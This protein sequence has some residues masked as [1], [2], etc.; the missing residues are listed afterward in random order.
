MEEEALDDLLRSIDASTGATGASGVGGGVQGGS[1]GPLSSKSNVSNAQ[2]ERELDELLGLVSPSNQQHQPQRLALP[3]SNPLGRAPPALLY[4]QQINNNQPHLHHQQQQLFVNQQYNSNNPFQHQQQPQ[5]QQLRQDPVLVSSSPM[6]LKKPSPQPA[7]ESADSSNDVIDLTDEF[8]DELDEFIIPERKPIPPPQKR[9]T[10]SSFP[11]PIAQRPFGQKTPG[12]EHQQRFRQGLIN[13]S[14]AS[15]SSSSTSSSPII[16]LENPADILKLKLEARERDAKRQEEQKRLL[17]EPCCFGTLHVNIVDFSPLHYARCFQNLPMMQVRL[18]P[19]TPNSPGATTGQAGTPADFKI[20]VIGLDVGKNQHHLGYI[21]KKV[22]IVLMR[23]LQQLKMD[24]WIPNTLPTGT[25][26]PIMLTLIGPRGIAATLGSWLLQ[27]NLF[28]SDV[29]TPNI[30]ASIPRLNPQAGFKSGGGGYMGTT[31][32]TTVHLNSGN[33]SAAEEA[34]TQIE[35]VY[36]SLTAAENLP[37]ME[38]DD[39][40]LTPMYAHQ[41]QALHFMSEKEKDVDFAKYDPKTSIWKFDGRGMY[42]NMITNEKT[43]KKPNNTKGGIL[44]DDMGLGKTIEVISLIMTSR[45][46]VRL[47]AVPAYKP[48]A[49]I[50]MRRPNSA[51]TSQPNSAPTTPIP[52]TVPGFPSPLTQQYQPSQ[53]QYPYQPQHPQN[54]QFFQHHDQ[55]LHQLLTQPPQQQ[56]QQQHQ[57]PQYEIFNVHDDDDEPEDDVMPVRDD[58]DSSLY[59]SQGTLIVCPLSTVQNWEEQFGAHVKPNTVKI[60]VYH[61]PNR[62][63]DPKELAKYDIVI[64]TYN[65]LSIEYG[66]DIKSGSMSVKNS[67][68]AYNDV[69]HT[70]ITV[71][72]TL[73]LVKWYRIVLD[74][75]H[76]IKDPNTAQ[77]KAACS[78]TG[79][80]RWALTGTPIQ[81]KLDDLFSLIKFLRIQPFCNKSSWNTF[82]SKP[83]KF[84]TNS[85]GV[86][87]LQTLM[88]SITLRRT[89]QQKINGKPILTLPERRDAIQYLDLAPTEQELYDKVHSKGRAFYHQ[90]RDS[91]NVMQHYVHLLEI[92]LRM[93]QVC[94]HKSLFKDWEQKL[95]E[96]DEQMQ[97]LIKDEVFPMLTKKR[98]L[99]ILSL[100]RESGDDSCCSCGALVDT[101]GNGEQSSQPAP[102]SASKKSKDE[103]KEDVKTLD[104]SAPACPMCSFSLGLKD[105]FELQ[106]TDCVE[107]DNLLGD[108]SMLEM[109]GQSTKIRK[110]VEDLVIVRQ[111]TLERKEPVTKSIIFSQWTTMLDLI[112]DPLSAAGFKFTRLDGK[113]ARNDRNIAMSRFKQD[114]EVTVLLLSLKAGGVGLNLTAAN[115]VYIMEPYW[116]PA[117]EAQA[118]DRVHR[119]G[120]TRIV[121]TIRFIAKG[122]IEENIHEL[123]RKKTELAQM[124]FK[125][126]NGGGGAGLDEG[127]DGL[128]Q[129]GK[130]REK[131]RENK[132]EMARQRM[133]DLDLLF[134]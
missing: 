17:Q 14:G 86:D 128:G 114:P 29:K 80:R 99:H 44:A 64:T 91:G 74:E 79:E 45:A 27:N 33:Q 69:T 31:G 73:Q 23:V 39:S 12:S 96:L 105:L 108:L 103:E 46:A 3:L 112:Q 113:M 121:N 72:S 88:K 11:V 54:Q 132:A 119:M 127:D 24:C 101:F 41:K 47:P 117:V 1:L 63:Q 76:I 118:I 57:Q 107:D 30:P 19:E 18:A 55:N 110:L 13:S 97:G 126:G 104:E 81:N 21:D 115:R 35:S 124:A 56:Q 106:E 40:I 6:S 37:Q 90:L 93:R 102:S 78:L 100:L 4:Q 95:K 59:P 34:K 125:G 25:S 15:S 67:G 60:C 53:Q 5:Q 66:K 7:K 131:A 26:L 42:I 9:K 71:N 109:D 43:S 123:Q 10:P 77:S 70:P 48:K 75:A 89:K 84:A 111:E 68:G 51:S 87:R 49:R 8:D 116:N 20:R 134:A 94:V 120:Q 50:S 16:D 82:I 92:I 83:I 62:L 133:L 36:N 28:L 130:R 61:G 85:I 52:T 129:K 38:P 32:V 98:A 122:T 2:T 65:L 58:D 22:T